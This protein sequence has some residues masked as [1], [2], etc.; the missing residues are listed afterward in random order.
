MQATKEGH[1]SKVEWLW[2][3]DTKTSTT[4]PKIITNDKCMKFYYDLK[5]LFLETNV[6]GVGLEVTLLQIIVTVNCG[7]DEVP[8]NMTLHPFA[9]ASK[10]L[11]S[12][13]W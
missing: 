10:S 5:P 13:E 4:K 2:I 12:T 11:S 1:I 9:F 6:S 8:N 7:H 3:D